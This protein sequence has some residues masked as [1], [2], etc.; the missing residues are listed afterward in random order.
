MQVCRYYYYHSSLLLWFRRCGEMYPNV[1]FFWRLEPD[2]VYTGNMQTLLNI[3]ASVAA[4]VMLPAY[5]K[6]RMVPGY[7]HWARNTE[8]LSRVPKPKWAWSLVSIGRFSRRYITD[9]MPR[10]WASMGVA[11]EEIS[12]PIS[13]LMET[14]C[15]LASFRKGSPLGAHIRF[16]PIYRCHEALR[17]RTRCRNEIWH[18]VKDR[19]CLI[20]FLDEAGS[21]SRYACAG[22]GVAYR[23]DVAV[24]LPRLQANGK[25]VI[26]HGTDPRLP[27]E[28]KRVAP[29]GVWMGE[30][31]SNAPTLWRAESVR[32][33]VAKRHS[34]QQ[35]TDLA[36]AKGR[37]SDE[38]A[39]LFKAYWVRKKQPAASRDS[40]TV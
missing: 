1:R 7:P 9:I 28:N 15:T 23:T 13:C 27:R 37:S 39:R 24:G 20:Q 22:A 21:S 8:Y 6:Q 40:A 30:N 31:K 17:A 18:P 19:E 32:R 11:Y 25:W 36:N 12:I 2:A 33:S 29:Y 16:T 35:K 26:D 5:Y 14:G 10:S 34:Q 4:D 3:S 38:R